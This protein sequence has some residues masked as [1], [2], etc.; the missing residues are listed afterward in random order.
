[1]E[2]AKK[3]FIVNPFFMIYSNG[4]YYLLAVATCEK[5]PCESRLSLLSIRQLM[6]IYRQNTQRSPATAAM[7]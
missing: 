5:K 7:R 4:K 1:M 3:D 6:W 2:T